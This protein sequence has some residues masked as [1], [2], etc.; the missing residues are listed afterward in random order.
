MKAHQ[1]IAVFVLLVCTGNLVD[2][3][4]AVVFNEVLDII[5]LAKDVVVTLAKAWNIVDQHV[6]F[7][8]IP[9]PLLD[10]TESKLFRKIGVISA[11]L[12]KVANRV[13]EVGK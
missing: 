4:S 12:D 3:S 9:I 1:H 8:D 6:D 5:T 7:G 13:D 2:R 11:R 10:R